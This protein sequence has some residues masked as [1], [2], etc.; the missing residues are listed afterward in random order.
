M[1][2]SNVAASTAASRALENGC[3]PG[4]ENR[5][6][7]AKSVANDASELKSSDER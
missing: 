4:F 2:G 7:F 1:L 5:A 6:L 3:V